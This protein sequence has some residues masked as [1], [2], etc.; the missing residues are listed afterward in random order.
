VRE[1]MRSAMKFAVSFAV[2]GV[3]VALPL[4]S[5]A[6]AGGTT[7]SNGYFISVAPL[8]GLPGKSLT[9]TGN[10]Q[11]Y[12]SPFSGD[13]CDSDDISATVTYKTGGG[14]QKSQLTDLGTSDGN[15]NVAG[16]VK[17][18]ADAGPTSVT[19]ATADVQA[20]CT[21]GSTYLSNVVQVTVLGNAKPAVSVKP[22]RLVV[23]THKTTTAKCTLSA[24][25]MTSC[26]VSVTAPNG[27]VIATGS[28]SNPAGSPLLL[29]TVTV[30]AK[31]VKLAAPAGGVKG[32]VHAV[33][34][35]TT[36]PVLNAKTSLVLTRLHQEL[37]LHSDVYFAFNSSKVSAGGAK[38]LDKVA[39][40]L[41]GA[42]LVECDG[43]TDS[44]GSVAY[45]RTLGL[46]RAKAV[47]AILGA[48][49]QHTKSIS[50]G[51]SHPV[52]SNATAAGRAK[53]RRVVV[54][55]TN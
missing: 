16:P 11:Y 9:V 1:P 51:E 23:D 42:Q 39:R 20:S 12:T 43:Y 49:V 48:H 19:G 40:Q 35:P 21:N 44:V 6:R 28:T 15:G 45:N 29:V 37:L 52:A 17:I 8:S 38:V 27:S 25:T 22:N 41:S 13:N 24:G 30:N 33:I 7:V 10:G 50:F 26:A 18:P 32:T 46:N 4:P 3:L 36:G 34:T 14:V 5:L 54:K 47:C 55:I 2:M 31:G 53:N